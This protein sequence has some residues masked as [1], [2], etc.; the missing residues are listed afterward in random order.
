MFFITYDLEIV[1]IIA[2]L[3]VGRYSFECQKI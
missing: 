1:E 3:L 2:I